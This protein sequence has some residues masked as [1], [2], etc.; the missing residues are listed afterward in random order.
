MSVYKALAAS[1]MSQGQVELPDGK[2]Y[3][4]SSLSVGDLLRV[5]QL[6][7]EQAGDTT[8]LPFYA[9]VAQRV[10]KAPRAVIESLSP[11]ALAYIVTMSQYG[12]EAIAKSIA[13]EAPASGNGPA[14]TTR[15]STSQKKR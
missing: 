7:E 2:V 6:S 12:V 1:A 4:V 14:A 8:V 13:A 10:T 9:D 15:R 5:Q 11:S 3:T